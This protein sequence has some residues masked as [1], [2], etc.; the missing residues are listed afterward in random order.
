MNLLV[1]FI[2]KAKKGLAN[3]DYK[4]EEAVRYQIVSPF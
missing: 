3:Q 1:D 2:V 4:N